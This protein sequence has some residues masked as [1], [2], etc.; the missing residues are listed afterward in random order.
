MSVM[1]KSICDLCRS[2]MNHK[3]GHHWDFDCTHNELL[4]Y[5]TH[6]VA[7]A[8]LKDTVTKACYAPAL[9]K[10][11]LAAVS[12]FWIPVS[13]VTGLAGDLWHHIV[14]TSKASGARVEGRQL[15]IGNS[16]GKQVC[17]SHYGH[18]KIMTAFNHQL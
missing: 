2:S 13:A 17:A 3:A 16:C 14:I 10:G 12:R 8:G 1:R 5:Y 18:S 11:Q 9:Y 4:L 7:K 15:V 6:L